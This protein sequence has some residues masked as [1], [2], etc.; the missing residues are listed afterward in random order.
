MIFFQE[1]LGTQDL[2]HYWTA[3]YRRILQIA[4]TD[5]MFRGKEKK[6]CMR[7]AEGLYL[8]KLETG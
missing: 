5:K 4:P 8:D 6:H 2:I 1:Y 7:A 3:A